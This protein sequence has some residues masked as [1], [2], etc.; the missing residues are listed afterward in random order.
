MPCYKPICCSYT[1]REDGKKDIKFS[2]G[3]C[4]AFYNDYGGDASH[5]SKH[6]DRY[7]QIPCGQCHGCRLE[8][9]RQW[10]VRCTHEQQMHDESCF[11]TLTFK[12]ECV[13]QD[14]SLNVKYFQSFIKRLRARVGIPGIK[15]LHCGE[16]GEQFGRPHYH[17]LLFGYDFPDKKLWQVRDDFRLYSSDLLHD[18]W[19]Y[20]F[21]SIGTVTFQSAGYVA[22]YSMKKITGSLADDHYT[23]VSPV[24]GRTYKVV[25]EYATMSRNPGLGASWFDKYY[26]SDI[27]NNGYMVINGHKCAP[28][29]Y[30]DDK[31]KILNPDLYQTLKATRI[32]NALKRSD[33]QTYDR[34]LVKERVRLSKLE[35]LIRTLD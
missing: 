15:Y 26:M 3:Y 10:A 19:P 13:P 22:R 5:Y 31:L 28:P 32:E 6:D 30:Y 17:A 7:L 35:Q 12:P 25:P 20:G 9:S 34:L 23:R 2:D 11:I 8:K 14:F 1:I 27:Y 33:D 4:R 29:R 24:D 18:L 16:Y 21:A